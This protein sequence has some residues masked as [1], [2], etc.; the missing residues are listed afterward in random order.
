M[1]GS[2]SQSEID[3]VLRILAG[4]PKATRGDVAATL[5]VSE[6]R[7]RHLIDRA[8]SSGS[9]S[10][11][12]ESAKRVESR[13]F[14][15]D[16]QT[17]EKT[18]TVRIK[19]LRQLCE[20]CEV[21]PSEWEVKEWSANKWEM[22]AVPRT[23]RSEKGKPWLRPSTKPIV[24]ELFQVKARFVRKVGV[25]KV[26][27][28]IANLIKLAEKH[29]PKY[30]PY[31]MR[32]PPSGNMLELHIPDLHLGK[33]A[34]GKETGYQDYDAKLAEETFHEAV[35]VMVERSR[36]YEYDKVVISLGNDFQQVDNRKDTTTA[37]TQVDTDSRY[38]K[39]AYK[40]IEIA[41]STI[42]R[43][44][45][46]AKDRHV[47]IVPGNHDEESAFHLGHKLQIWYRQ[48]PDVTVDNSPTSRKYLRF[49]RVG[50]MWTHGHQGKKIDYGLLFATERPDVFGPAGS[51]REIHTGHLH[52]EMVIERMGVKVR[53]VDA[54]CPADAW[55]S[56]NAYVGQLRGAQG[57][58]WSKEL[59][60]LGTIDYTVPD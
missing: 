26:K 57:Y 25:V 21:D 48:C 30:A 52:G 27:T 24:T 55:H 34:W 54:L 45:T 5:G 33:L 2:L 41:V 36:H 18:T 50:L 59:G 31:V 40:A 3:D 51:V 49:G 7:A 15:G 22:A 60:L 1:Q 56:N 42:D 32:R 4:N 38:P 20:V 8:K 14:K 35:R 53:I 47:V 37:G 17:V 23:T 6:G 12:T 39:L 43:L 46:V 58:M 28:E 13:S 9:G 19:T 29:S 44:A 16:E 11:T 10:K